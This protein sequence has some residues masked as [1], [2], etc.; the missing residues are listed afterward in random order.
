MP[1]QIRRSPGVVKKTVR[2]TPLWHRWSAGRWGPRCPRWCELNYPNF[3]AGW[4]NA[5]RCQ[6]T[7]MRKSGDPI[8]T[9]RTQPT[10]V[11]GTCTAASPSLKGNHEPDTMFRITATARRIPTP[12]ARFRTVFMLASSFNGYAYAGDEGCVR[13]GRRARRRYM[14]TGVLPTSLSDLRTCLFFEGRRCHWVIEVGTLAGDRKTA[15]YVRALVEAI[16]M[17][18]AARPPRRM[19]KP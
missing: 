12:R 3:K 9:Q 18:V 14:E 11:P 4:R 5:T 1:G 10:A 2:R 17:K 19:P 13:M 8:P 6:A 15:R 7:S 16:R